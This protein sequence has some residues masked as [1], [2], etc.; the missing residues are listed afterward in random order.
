MK[1]LVHLLEHGTAAEARSRLGFYRSLIPHAGVL[2]AS[3]GFVC[4]LCGST[5]RSRQGAVQ[6]LERCLRTKQKELAVATVLAEESYVCSRCNRH[7]A[8]RDDALA[9][10]PGQLEPGSEGSELWGISAESGEARG[11]TAAGLQSG[12]LWRRVPAKRHGHLMQVPLKL[13][14]TVPLEPTRARDFSQL[15]PPL[16]G[17]GQVRPSEDLPRALSAL[18]AL[19]VGGQQR[20]A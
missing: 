20:K 16:P 1:S 2:L 19:L 7:Y 17:L 15:R 8:V 5:H 4:G 11:G 14:A 10:H 18:G 3:D 6:C 9:C 12:R 13:E